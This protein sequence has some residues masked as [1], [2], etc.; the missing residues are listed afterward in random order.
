MNIMTYEL[1]H[2]WIDGKALLGSRSHI[3]SRGYFKDYKSALKSMQ[4]DISRQATR[5]EEGDENRTLHYSIIERQLN[6]GGNNFHIWT[7][8]DDGH[9]IY[10]TTKTPLNEEA[11]PILF[12]VNQVV[13]V[14]VEDT[15]VEGVIRGIQDHGTLSDCKSQLYD[16]QT[17]LT[18]SQGGSH[19]GI[20]PSCL[21]IPINKEDME[22]HRLYWLAL[23][24][25]EMSELEKFAKDLRHL[26]HLSL[27]EAPLKWPEDLIEALAEESIVI[28][29][30]R[31]T[32]GL[33]NKGE[34]R[35]YREV[36]GLFS[37]RSASELAIATCVAEDPF[38]SW[39]FDGTNAKPETL[40]SEYRFSAVRVAGD[41]YL[42]EEDEQWWINASWSFDRKGRC[43]GCTDF[44]NRKI[45]GHPAPEYQY[46]IGDI[47]GV[48]T[49]D[50]LLPGLVTHYPSVSHRQ[51]D[52]HIPSDRLYVIDPGVVL[53]E[54]EHWDAIQEADM[55]LYEEPI[56]PEY[57]L[58]LAR[59]L[60]PDEMVKAII[61]K[62]HFGN[63]P[64]ED[65]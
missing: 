1:R 60:A 51:I 19:R 5:A 47:V 33:S 18:D 42:G 29:L 11:L 22:A 43:I 59:M 63:S 25:L 4:K 39:V 6:Q 35:I 52:Y 34:N 58:R 31:S 21:M 3:D 9:L 62:F 24:C 17:A 23:E 30:T 54:V 49:P 56:S 57:R 46:H 61:A 2:S 50:G 48:Q 8:A 12:T 55:V 7:F 16:V 28:E 26:F 32:H 41:I 53:P 37:S 20:F 15:W 40:V 27:P 38:S 65:L 14:F 44:S 36:L 45:E 64:P 13:G 10:G